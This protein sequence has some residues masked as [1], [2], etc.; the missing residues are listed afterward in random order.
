M[1]ELDVEYIEFVDKTT[2]KFQEEINDNTLILIA[3]R[4]PESNTR[5]IDNIE[6]CE[7]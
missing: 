5:L 4:T 6:L 7:N 2:F 3:A 1:E